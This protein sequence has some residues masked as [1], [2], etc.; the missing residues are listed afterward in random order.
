MD[1]YYT[2]MKRKWK[3][4]LVLAV[5]VVA[6]IAVAVRHFAV[7]GLPGWVQ[8]RVWQQF[9][10]AGLL[11]RGDRM[12]LAGVNAVRIDG[13]RLADAA[14]PDWALAE[15][16]QLTVSVLP[17]SGR[18]AFD[19]SGGEFNLP[20]AG[21]DPRPLR[22]GGVE[23]AGLLAPD[24]FIRLRSFAGDLDGIELVLTG[25]AAISSTTDTD[26]ASPIAAWQ[27]LPAHLHEAINE[28]R[29]LAASA[30]R[31]ARARVAIDFEAP[32]APAL[33]RARVRCELM[34]YLWRGLNVRAL[35]LTADVQA[36]Q[37]SISDLD[38]SYDDDERLQGQLLLTLPNRML[39][40]RLQLYGYAIKFIKAAATTSL[41]AAGLPHAG[42]PLLMRVRLFPSPLAQPLDWHAEGL[43]SGPMVR[44]GDVE[45][46][47]ASAEFR[48]HQRV[49]TINNAHARA[50]GSDLSGDCSIYLPD[51][52]VILDGVLDGQPEIIGEFLSARDRA[53]YLEVWRMFTW[54]SRRQRPHFEVDLY[55]DRQRRYSQVLAHAEMSDID[56]NGVALD[57]LAGDFIFDGQALALVISRLDATQ[58]GQS[59]SGGAAVH[60]RRGE[61]EVVYTAESDFAPAAIM[62]M[63]DLPWQ[64]DLEHHAVTC[65]PRETWSSGHVYL[66]APGKTAVDTAIQAATLTAAGCQATGAEL[67]ITAQTGDV[68]WDLTA[69]TLTS[70]PWALADIEA[71][72]TEAA[73]GG[74]Q[75]AGSVG[76]ATGHGMTA[77]TTSCRAH[78][79][80]ETVSMTAVSEEVDVAGWRLLE[81]ASQTRV[82][83]E[84]VC[85]A[86]DAAQAVYE[87][88]RAEGLTADVI[89]LP[90]QLAVALG[91]ASVTAADGLRADGC[92]LD[93]AISDDLTEGQGRAAALTYPPVELTAQRLA[94]VGMARAGDREIT[95]TAPAVSAF[96]QA[97]LDDVTLVLSRGADGMWEQRSSAAAGNWGENVQASRLTATGRWDAEADVSIA[98]AELTLPAARLVDASGVIAQEGDK[99][100]LARARADLCGGQ[101]RGSITYDWA[102]SRGSMWWSA[103]GIDFGKLTRQWQQEAKDEAGTASKL[104]DSGGQLNAE[105]NLS[106]NRSSGTAAL[107]GDGALRVTDG[108]FLSVPML[109]EFLGAV[110]KARVFGILTPGKD[111]SR[112][113]ELSGDLAFRDQ[114]I[115]IRR[116]RS[117]GDVVAL[118]ADGLY[119]W[120][121]N[122]LDMRWRAVFFKPLKKLVP[123]PDWLY[124]F[125]PITTLLERRVH[126]PIAELKWEE[127]SRIKEFFSGSQ[128][129]SRSQTG[130]R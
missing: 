64:S 50:G 55:W 60:L 113:T 129:R 28:F 88:V 49:F 82:R 100:S 120:D 41:P 1:G 71:T 36:D 111:I 74:W 43:V 38:L 27:Q 6:A 51:G 95:I 127:L 11:A 101:I 105:V 81:V 39:S 106:I 24:E 21:A 46:T 91:A 30:S 42:E 112:I 4:I 72:V 94:A 7:I 116:L 47:R 79:D 35:H 63:Y 118:D 45:L 83:G 122:W 56:Y 73:A 62:Q 92:E 108:N 128:G 20:P 115:Q 70:G 9:A 26:A 84:A 44:Y 18:L 12:R 10:D 58:R 13:L 48:L 121:R 119:D 125:S 33:P 54:R 23:A 90:G 75:I 69:A 77:L 67:L 2:E 110:S 93:L 98:A 65:G 16:D 15:I 96:E 52:P 25:E 114:E 126:G 89:S 78:A 123:L 87:E 109:S 29:G 103:V 37:V 97:H 86:G 104:K 76:S 31:D 22:V 68:T 17:A 124:P 66:D 99:L 14:S 80:G 117:N 61:R 32:E 19:L 102:T 85:V 3:I 5:V 8:A 40:G 107:E 57:H 130:S 59:I 34:H 53:D